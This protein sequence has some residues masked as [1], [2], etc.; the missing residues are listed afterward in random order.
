MSTRP[1]DATASTGHRS[2]G[3][4]HGELSDDKKSLSIAQH[5]LIK[6]D[7]LQWHMLLTV[8]EVAAL[9]ALLDH[10]E[11]HMAK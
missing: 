11:S 6:G 3:A 9:R 8:E 2:F 4:F 1:V 5:K 10:F 7:D